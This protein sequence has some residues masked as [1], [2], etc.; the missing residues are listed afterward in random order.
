M[1]RTDCLQEP[2]RSQRRAIRM[3]GSCEM[4]WHGSEILE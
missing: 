1:R 3:T 2:L 4:Y